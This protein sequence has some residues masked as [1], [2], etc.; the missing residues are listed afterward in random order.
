MEFIRDHVLS[1]D[2]THGRVRL[3]ETKV[4]KQITIALGKPGDAPTVGIYK[5]E[6]D[7][8]VIASSSKS[9]KLIPT[10]FEPDADAGIEVMILERSKTLP[11]TATKA[12]PPSK[13]SSRDLQKEIDQ[14]RA[15]LQRLEKELKGPK[16]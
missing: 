9:P 12:D 3:D 4:P 2:G 5:L 1:A 13:P 14:L 8:L 7:K 16:D 10:G 11:P 15:Q 6:G